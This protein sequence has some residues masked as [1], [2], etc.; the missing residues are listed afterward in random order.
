MSHFF[1]KL[2]S[3]NHSGKCS[4]KMYYLNTIPALLLGI[5]VN[6]NLHLSYKLAI[7]Y[8]ESK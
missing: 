4:F 8:I 7:T 6:K 2:I 1:F 3:I 5:Y